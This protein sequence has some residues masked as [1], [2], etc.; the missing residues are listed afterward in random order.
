TTRCSSARSRA[1][2]SRA[3]RPAVAAAAAGR[4]GPA[5][6]RSV[7]R[8]AFAVYVAVL[9]L[10]R[11]GLADL[12]DLDVEM[13][14]LAGHRMVHVDI[15][16]GG[17]DLDHGHR[18]RADAGV[19]D[20]LLARQQALLADVLLRHAHDHALAALAIGLFGFQ[21]HFEAVAGGLALHRR[22]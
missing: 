16:D 2:R 10:D 19:D 20:D 3:A 17:A 15:D 6:R 9:D 4:S 12:D 1:A 21:G 11:L 7:L 5:R 22:L 8:A 14:R 13:Q 18:A